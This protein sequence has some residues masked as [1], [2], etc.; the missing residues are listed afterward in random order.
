MERPVG[1]LTVSA[2]V[3]PF[4]EFVLTLNPNSNGV[5][6]SQA[7]TCPNVNV[8]VCHLTLLKV[9]PPTLDFYKKYVKLIP[10][11]G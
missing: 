7:V 6:K 10:E 5:A 8:V 11:S 3:N 1:Q 9:N 2:I 4:V